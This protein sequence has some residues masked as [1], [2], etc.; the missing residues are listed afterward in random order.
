MLQVQRVFAQIFPLASETS[1]CDN[2]SVFTVNVDPNRSPGDQWQWYTAYQRTMGS[3]GYHLCR[4]GRRRHVG[5]FS[6]MDSLVAG[7][8]LLSVQ[9][10]PK[11]RWP[12]TMEHS[13]P[14][15]RQ[16]GLLRVYAVHLPPDHGGHS[17]TSIAG[18]SIL[19]RWC[20][21][22]LP[23]VRFLELCWPSNCAMA[24]LCLSTGYA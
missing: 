2:S 6:R 23:V 20:G 8:S 17:A 24:F 16:Y 15:T 11:S 21:R 18:G 22:G 10:L 4:R 7:F 3:Q 14:C 19:S 13:D 1:P 9:G 5:S 12:T